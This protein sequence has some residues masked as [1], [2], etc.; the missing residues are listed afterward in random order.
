[1]KLTAVLKRECLGH[2]RHALR[3]ERQQPLQAQQDIENEEAADMEQQHG[4]R[5][6]EPVLLARSRRRRRGDRGRLS[7]G[8]RTGDRKVR[9]PLKTRVMY[10]PSGFTSATTIA[11]KIA[12]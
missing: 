8:R 2:G 3:I 12:I 6:G 4:D 7:T 11:Q 5:V 10:Q 9:S 1:M